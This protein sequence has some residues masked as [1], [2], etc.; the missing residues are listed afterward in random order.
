[1]GTLTGNH[2]AVINRWSERLKEARQL[3]D[4]AEAQRLMD[5]INATLDGAA[6]L[7]VQMIDKVEPS[8][9]RVL[10]QNKQLLD[11]FESFEADSLEE[12]RGEVPGYQELIETFADTYIEWL[13]AELPM[14]VK[15][16][17]LYIQGVEVG[18]LRDRPWFAEWVEMTKR[19]ADLRERL[20]LWPY[21]DYVVRIPPWAYL[22]SCWLLLWHT[23]RHPFRTTVI[24]LMTGRVVGF[25]E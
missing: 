16:T 3:T 15:F 18:N 5:Q 20:R 13:D 12:P 10:S 21:E 9:L 22:K 4:S 14:A 25:K 19:M 8:H 6:A 23:I 17:E 24:D 1:M 7:L 11:W 2:P